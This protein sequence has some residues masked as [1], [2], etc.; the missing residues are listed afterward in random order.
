MILVV[1]AMI[2]AKV[3][4]LKL[5][6]RARR[7]CFLLR[8]LCQVTLLALNI[9]LKGCNNTNEREAENDDTKPKIDDV[10]LSDE[11]DYRALTD[12]QASMLQCTECKTYFLT[13]DYLSQHL[14]T[15]H[16]KILQKAKTEPSEEKQMYHCS[17]CGQSFSSL[18]TLAA[19]KNE[20]H[21]KSNYYI[22]NDADIRAKTFNFRHPTDSRDLIVDGMDG[23]DIKQTM[24]CIQSTYTCSKCGQNFN[25]LQKLAD[26][27]NELHLKYPK[28]SKSKTCDEC[29]RTFFSEQ[30]L[31]DHMIIIHTKLYPHLCDLCGKG[32]TVKQFSQ[33]FEK[34]RR[35]CG[36]KKTKTPE[37]VCQECGKSFIK[38]AKFKRH[39][40][41]H[42]KTK[43]FQCSDCEKAFA[44]KV[45]LKK[46]V[47]RLHPSSAHQFE[48][49]RKYECTFCHILFYTKSDVE[50]HKV[51]E[52]GKKFF[53]CCDIC[54]K[55]FINKAHKE[56]L[57]THRKTCKL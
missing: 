23:V 38:L 56:K 19:H 13:V 54:G 14:I 24:K 41:F 31:Q 40:I 18:E 34:H 9:L 8:F 35:T 1:C 47:I 44:D 25:T 7:I 2:L 36:I 5:C 6:L 16:N 46:H 4:L 57:R 45:T 32:F 27:K 10:Q 11:Q 12:I 49:E 30:T 20:K 48:R 15:V 28:R 53:I 33:L 17:K 39:M 52:H 37:R 26:H 50:Y 29:K 43:D 42:T 21:V 22:N 51:E 55:G 3:L